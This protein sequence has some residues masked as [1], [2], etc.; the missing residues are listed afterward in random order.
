MRNLRM[1]MLT[2]VY[3]ACVLST[4]KFVGWQSI[5]DYGFRLDFAWFRVVACQV[6]SVVAISLGIRECRIRQSD[7]FCVILCLAVI[8]QVFFGHCAIRKLLSF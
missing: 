2:V 4:A 6:V 8:A 1:L 3:V 7:L 5:D